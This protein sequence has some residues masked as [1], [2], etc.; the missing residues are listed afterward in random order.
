MEIVNPHSIEHRTH[1]EFC[2][3]AGRETSLNHEASSVLALVR[4]CAYTDAR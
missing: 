3:P 1:F 4:P 2:F